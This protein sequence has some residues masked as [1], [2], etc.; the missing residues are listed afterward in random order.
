MTESSSTSDN[1]R[2]Y[3]VLAMLVAVYVLN[4]LD[5]QIISILAVPI[6]AE[7]HLSDAQMGWMGGL[8]FGAVY[9]ILGVPAAWAADRTSRKRIIAAALILW[10]GFTAAC[11]FTQSFAQLFV[12]RMGVGIG[13]AGGVAPGYSLISS[14][15][16]P[17]SRARA[18]AVYSLG[19]PIGVATGTFVGGL[20]A[21]DWRRAFVVVGLAGLVVAVPFLF[22]VRE[23]GRDAAP[24]ATPGIASVAKM[25]FAKPSFWLLSLA[26]GCSSLVGYGILFWFPSFL[27]RSF[28]FTLPH[29][30]QFIAMVTLIGGVI[31]ILSGGILADRIGQA[32]KAAYAVIPAIAFLISAPLYAL[33]M[34]APSP[35]VAFWLFLVPQAL[36]LMWLGP[37]VT[38]VQH[39]GPAQSR[40]QMSAL[41]LLVNSLIG[42]GL[43]PY[44]F[45]KVS[46][47]LKPEHGAD[48]IKYAF[49]AGLGFYVVAAVLLLIASRRLQKD[50]VA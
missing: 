40:S 18:L 49:L 14:W 10:S 4:F 43:G 47:L 36:S 24:A 5:R 22:L 8:A 3:L 11:G 17:R 45:G 48:S 34:L 29:A 30:G 1:G 25:A 20:L 35:A 19:I 44:F 31:G 27:V 39:L 12:A 16:P 23:P 2:R 6:K 42:L 9:S 28:H 15:F 41:V 26:A 50:W 7:F 37:L 32:R 33:G 13:E 21:S 46:D 38:A